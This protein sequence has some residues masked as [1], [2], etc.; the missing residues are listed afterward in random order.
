M[1]L[2]VVG[3]GERDRIVLTRVLRRETSLEF[4]EDFVVWGHFHQHKGLARKLFF[5]I[6]D[7]EELGFRALVASTDADGDRKRR[8]RNLKAGRE[9]HREKYAAFP[10]ALAV[11]DP[12]SEA[13]LLDDPSAVRS[14]LRLPANATIPNVRTCAS[15]KSAL[16]ELWMTS[17]R[18]FD[19][20]GDTELDAIADCAAQIDPVRCAHARETGF[21]DFRDEIG[22]ELG[23]LMGPTAS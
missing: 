17:P 21:A 11:P 15:P 12:H 8:L 22:R 18:Q 10:T 4:R 7:A 2:R 9:S 1:R 19:A 5:A 6:L 20:P 23:V 3:E 14:A 13:W 16:H